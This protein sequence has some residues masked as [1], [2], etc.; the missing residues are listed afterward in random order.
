MTFWFHLCGTWHPFLS[1]NA[2]F[3]KVIRAARIG[4]VKSFAVLPIPTS[5]FPD[6]VAF[7]WLFATRM[8]GNTFPNCSGAKTSGTKLKNIAILNSR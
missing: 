6:M 7:F 1:K 4:P 2:R 5:P 8:I 3:Y